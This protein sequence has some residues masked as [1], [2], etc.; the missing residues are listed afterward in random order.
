MSEEKRK[1]APNERSTVLKVYVSEGEAEQIKRSAGY[2]STSNYIRRTLLLAA[3][4]RYSWEISMGDLRELTAALHEYNIRMQGLIGALRY[5]TDLYAED[6]QHFMELAKDTNK[7]VMAAYQK[8]LS[9][10][11]SVKKRMEKHL[12]E[13]LN[14]KLAGE[15]H[16]QNLIYGRKGDRK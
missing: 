8:I 4:G 16:I 5:R 14:E 10:R 12:K 11:K 1:P 13:Q 6:I 9:D 7:T 3:N 2:L 15:E